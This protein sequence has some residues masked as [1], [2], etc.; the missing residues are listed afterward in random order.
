L[1]GFLGGGVGGLGRL[2][3]GVHGDGGGGG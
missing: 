3:I 2:V 1:L